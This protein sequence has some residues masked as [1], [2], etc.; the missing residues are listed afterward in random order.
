MGGYLDELVFFRLMEACSFSVADSGEIRTVA[1]TAAS[2]D[3][4][5]R[6]STLEAP[7]NV[8]DLGKNKDL[9]NNS[10]S[11]LVTL[12]PYAINKEAKNSGILKSPILYVEPLP[13]DWSFDFIYG[14]F[15]K[16]GPIK[17]IRNRLGKNHEFF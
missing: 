3:V 2:A 6:G 16:F 15:S 7:R 8:D 11:S 4:D 9:G 1:L 17:E 14:E 5:G 10:K 13:L 12:E